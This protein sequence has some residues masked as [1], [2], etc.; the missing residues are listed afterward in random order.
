MRLTAADVA[1][2]NEQER[3]EVD[4]VPM[5]PFG[6]RPADAAGGVNAELMCLDEPSGNRANRGKQRSDRP[7]QLAP[8][9]RID[10]L[11]RDWLEPALD[12]TVERIVGSGLPMSAVGRRRQR[13]VG[14]VLHEAPVTP[15]AIAS[16]VAQIHVTR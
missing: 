13:P 8:H 2:L 3:D 16:A 15:R 7:Q 14:K 6:S 9:G 4:S 11:R 10:N 5:R 12:A 1:T